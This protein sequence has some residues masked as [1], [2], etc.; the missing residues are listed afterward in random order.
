[1]AAVVFACQPLTT[2]DE[3]VLPSRRPANLNQ[4]VETHEVQDL[5]REFPFAVADGGSTDLEYPGNCWAGL[6]LD[7]ERDDCLLTWLQLGT[8][9]LPIELCCYGH[10]RICGVI[11]Q[12]VVQLP[13]L[14]AAFFIAGD[15]LL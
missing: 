2:G 14:T 9:V 5:D 12:N 7:H 3:I 8:Q 11:A 10:R 13:D 15:D 1:M 4:D 6:S